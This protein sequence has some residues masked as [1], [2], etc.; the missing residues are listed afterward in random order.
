MNRFIINIS[1]ICYAHD[2]YQL[3]IP[4]IIFLNLQKIDCQAS[5]KHYCNQTQTIQLIS[6]IKVK[7]AMKSI[8]KNKN[9]S[10]LDGLH[11]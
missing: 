11:D 10:F 1:A 4:K 9:L 7:M 2:S 8:R 3:D 6:A 5:S